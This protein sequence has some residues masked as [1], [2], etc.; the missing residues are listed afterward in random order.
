MTEDADRVEL[1]LTV[2][3]RRRTAAVDPRSLLL[4]ALRDD[5][6]ATAPKAGCRTG[7]CGACT[8]R[9]DGAIAKSCLR[10]AV[11][12]DGADVDT[13]ASMADG[14]ELTALQRA[15]WDANAFQ[16]GFCLS[17]M[18][19][20]AEDLLERVAAPT[21]AEVREALSGNLCRC[22]GYDAIVD[23]VLRCGSDGGRSDRD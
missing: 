4:D 13:I 20:A 15:F 6:G 18:L 17:G 5:F 9:V 3:G 21:E 16:C 2:D 8:V 22:T 12:E 23:A 10:L 14:E 7:D 19:F 11:A 1:T